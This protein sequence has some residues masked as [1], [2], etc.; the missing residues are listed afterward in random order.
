[1]SHRKVLKRRISF[2]EEPD[3]K[4]ADRKPSPP[5]DAFQAASGS[6]TLDTDEIEVRF[7]GHYSLDSPSPRNNT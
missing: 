2:T 1:M 6:A 4:K 3:G 5:G 7:S